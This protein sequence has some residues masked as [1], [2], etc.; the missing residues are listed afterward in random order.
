M[1]SLLTLLV[2]FGLSGYLLLQA[3]CDIPPSHMPTP[4]RS[5]SDEIRFTNEPEQDEKDLP[6]PIQKIVRGTT[7]TLQP[8]A[9]Y[10]I[11]AR[12][13]NRKRYYLSPEVFLAPVDLAL[14]WKELATD[15]AWKTVEF[16]HG[17]R[18]YHFRP[19][20]GSPFSIEQIYLNSA[21]THIIPANERMANVVKNISVGDKVV[22]E[23]YLVNVSAPGGWRWETSLVRTDQGGG[24]CELLYM[25]KARVE[26]KEY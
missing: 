18:F 14:A 26:N 6:P 23:G 9:N 16:E 5:V 21:N 4:T 1:K 7:Y 19:K 25:T 24:A 12:V 10:R 11:T 22:L 13:V 15:G 8:M 17:N 20:T 3:G 2:A